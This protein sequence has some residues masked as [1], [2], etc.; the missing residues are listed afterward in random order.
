MKYPLA[1]LVQEAPVTRYFSFLSFCVI[2]SSL[3]VTFLLPPALELIWE[4]LPP[5]KNGDFLSFRRAFYTIATGLSLSPM[6]DS[7]ALPLL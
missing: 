1:S 6:P 4:G 5:D 7:F 3:L 2:L